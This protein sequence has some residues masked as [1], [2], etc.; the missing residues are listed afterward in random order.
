MRISEK[1]IIPK[2]IVAPI[3]GFTE[4]KGLSNT[5]ILTADDFETTLTIVDP[6]ADRTVYMPNATGYLP[7]LAVASTTTITATP[8]ELNLLDGVSGL[9][10]ADLTK[11]AAI[12]TSAADLN[13]SATT[14]KAIAMAIVFG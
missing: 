12:D 9:V 2:N 8:A 10:Q 5:I 3:Y 1:E 6:T 14:G 4:Q 13:N 11:L 7:L